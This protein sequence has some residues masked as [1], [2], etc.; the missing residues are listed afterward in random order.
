LSHFTPGF[1][2]SCF[3]RD[4]VWNHTGTDSQEDETAKKMKQK[5]ES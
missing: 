4:Q 3:N 1:A 2:N 5:P